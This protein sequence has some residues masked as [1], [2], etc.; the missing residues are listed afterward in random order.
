MNIKKS[1][2][3][4]ALLVGVNAGIVAVPI[5]LWFFYSEASTEDNKERRLRELYYRY[6]TPLETAQ[7][8][9]ID[10]AVRIKKLTQILKNIIKTDGTI[11][12]Y[13][14]QKIGYPSS[15]TNETT[16]VDA[17]SAGSINLEDIEQA[18]EIVAYL[19]AGR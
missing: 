15:S 17:L 2:I 14:I 19:T 16:T 11:K 12:G 8:E 10:G 7:L 18:G 9:P 4:S 1:L 5:D 13:Q 6:P 3:L